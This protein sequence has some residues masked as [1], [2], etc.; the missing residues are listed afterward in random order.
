MADE[1][2]NAYIKGIT[3]RV[4]IKEGRTMVISYELI[5]KPLDGTR[6]EKSIKAKRNLANKKRSTKVA[7]CGIDKRSLDPYGKNKEAYR[8]FF[9]KEGLSEIIVALRIK[10]RHEN[11]CSLQSKN[12][13]GPNT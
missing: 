5:G 9:E 1:G 6:V 10:D 11:Q 4:I 3:S 7:T 8:K 13:N 12:G 2:V